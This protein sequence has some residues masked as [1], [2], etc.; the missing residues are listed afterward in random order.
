MGTLICYVLN[1]IMDIYTLASGERDLSG[2]KLEINKLTKQVTNC[3]DS[4][5]HY[6]GQKLDLGFEVIGVILHILAIHFALRS[7]KMI[8]LP[9]KLPRKPQKK[10]KK[11]YRTSC[12]SS[13]AE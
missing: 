4:K 1:M 10:T 9:K 7:R 2:Y 6:Y 3:S 8:Q 5:N 12:L 13:T 11:K